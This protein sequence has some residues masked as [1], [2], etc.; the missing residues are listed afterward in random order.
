MR[1]FLKA[2]GWAA[3]FAAASSAALRAAS[4]AAFSASLSSAD[5]VVVLEPSAS[6][7]AISHHLPHLV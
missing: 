3:S 1:G 4:A 6:T 7:P 5:F 2:S